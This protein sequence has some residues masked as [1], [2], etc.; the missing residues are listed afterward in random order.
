MPTSIDEGNA[1]FRS[2]RVK[3]EMPVFPTFKLVIVRCGPSPCGLGAAG[4]NSSWR[5]GPWIES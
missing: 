3:I 4:Q 1:N 5:N 2:G